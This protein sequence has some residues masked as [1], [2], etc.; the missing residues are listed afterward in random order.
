MPGFKLAPNQ[1]QDLQLDWDTNQRGCHITLDGKDAGV[2]QDNRH[3]SGLNYLRLRSTANGPDGGLLIA[4]VAAD[5]SAG[6]PDPP[7][8]LHSN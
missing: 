3:S 6:W 7:P 4:S 8:D 1:W 5:V 2:L